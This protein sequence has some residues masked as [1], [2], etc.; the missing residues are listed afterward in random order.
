MFWKKQVKKRC[1]PCVK[2]AIFATAAISGLAIL[3]KGK[4][5]AM[6]KMKEMM[7]AIKCA[8]NMKKGS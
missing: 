3:K 4:E 2:L 6:C 7:K 8:C 5:M 1:N